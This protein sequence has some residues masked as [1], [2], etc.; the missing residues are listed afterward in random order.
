LQVSGFENFGL[1][2][3][4]LQTSWQSSAGVEGGLPVL[5]S[6][7][8]VTAFY[9]RS[10]LTDLRDPNSGDYVLDDYLVRR[11]AEAYG[12][13]VLLRRPST[14]VLHGWLSYTLSRSVRL[15]EAGNVGPSV[16]DQR[17]VLNLVVGY[18]LGEWTLGAKGHLNTG[19][20]VP[21]ANTLPLQTDRLPLYYQ[22]DLRAERRFVFDRYTLTGY[23]ELL[24]ATF[25]RQI[26][27]LAD[28]WNGRQASGYS[29]VVPSL[30]L[31]GDF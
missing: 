14:E 20:P 2:S 25:N 23:A 13:E 1:A 8:S 11:D 5:G 12:A 19:R 6:S 21:V 18:R 4:G 3:Y 9:Q 24:N 30:G 22:I 16:W 7:F 15:F 28:G 17:H 10:K 29:V 26:D 27:G 31:R